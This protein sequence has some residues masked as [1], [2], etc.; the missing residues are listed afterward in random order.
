MIEAKYQQKGAFAAMDEDLELI[1]GLTFDEWLDM[2]PVDLEKMTE[3]QKQEALREVN[4][5][6]AEIREKRADDESWQTKVYGKK[7]DGSSADE[8]GRYEIPKFEPM[9]VSAPPTPYYLSMR[10][11]GTPEDDER[12]MRGVEYRKA[13]G[14][15]MTKE[16]VFA[17]LKAAIDGVKN[18]QA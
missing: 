15:M 14:K 2:I 11:T 8:Y 5:R 3:T 12:L 17:G 7:D 1:D 18:A 16:E 9:K 10:P 13:G 4:I 6:V